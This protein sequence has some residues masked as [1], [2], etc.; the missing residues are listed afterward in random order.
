MTPVSPSAGA[1]GRALGKFTDSLNEQEKKDFSSSTLPD[2][3]EVISNIQNQKQ[4]VG[5]KRNLHRLQPFI[6]AMDQYVKAI[7]TFLDGSSF[8]A[9]IWV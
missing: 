1:F 6:E 9:V 3:Y 4:S 5:K 2:L 7:E 8:V